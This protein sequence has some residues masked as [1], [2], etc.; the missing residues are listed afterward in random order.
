MITILGWT[1]AA[2]IGARKLSNSPEFRW[3]GINTGPVTLSYWA[4]GQPN[5]PGIQHCVTTWA[6][7]LHYYWGDHDCNTKLYFICEVK[8]N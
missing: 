2:W 6:E 3:Y 5:L 1:G 7:G 8:T 4:V